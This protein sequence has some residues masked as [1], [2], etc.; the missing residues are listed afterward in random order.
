MEEQINTKKVKVPD[1]KVAIASIA[2]GVALGMLIAML[3][4]IY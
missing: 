1:Y 2:T 4:Y 3:A